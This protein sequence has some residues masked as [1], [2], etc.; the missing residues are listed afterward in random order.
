M[1]GIDRSTV[2]CKAGSIDPACRTHYL[3]FSKNYNFKGIT[4]I[5]E[6]IS[7]I[8]HKVVQ[9]SLKGH[10]YL[11][12]ALKKQISQNIIT[13]DRDSKIWLNSTFMLKS[14][15]ILVYMVKIVTMAYLSNL[16]VANYI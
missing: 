6:K 14:R 15:I 12:F 10:S 9:I 8:G 16:N 7:L 2:T 11:F 13:V 5:F 1:I 3:S 4:A